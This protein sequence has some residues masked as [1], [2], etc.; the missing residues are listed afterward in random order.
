MRI[1]D[2]VRL[3]AEESGQPVMECEKFYDT[4]MMLIEERILAGEDVPFKNLFTIKVKDTPART[5]KCTFNGKEYIVPERKAV[6]FRVSEILKAKL[7][8]KD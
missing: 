2:F 4:F 1:K 7:I 8:G 3:I 6:S 5:V